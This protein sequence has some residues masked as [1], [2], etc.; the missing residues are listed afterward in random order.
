MARNNQSR[1]EA[2]VHMNILVVSQYFWPENFRINDLVQELKA[3]GHDLTVLTGLPNYPTG[4]WFSGYGLSAVGRNSWNKV[5]VVRVPV[6][7]RMSAKGWQL[8]LNYLS[9]AFSASL[10]GPMLCRGKFD[11]I[12][13][14]E[15]SP[16]TVGVPGMVMRKI[17]RAPM[18]F[19]VQDLWP[20]SL[21][22]T[23]AV[24]SQTILTIVGRMVRAIYRRCDQVL[25]QS[26]GFIEPAVKAGAR[27]ENIRYFPNWAEDF[28]H[29]FKLSPNAAQFSEVPEGFCIIFAGNLGTAQSLETIIG[30]AELLRNINGIQWVV[31][32]DGRRHDW[33]KSEIRRKGLDQ[34]VHFLGR[35]P[36]EEMPKYFALADVLLA[37]LRA[38]PVFSLTIPSKIQTY[39]ACGRPIVAALDGE[40]ARIINESGGGIAVNAGDAAGLARAVKQMYDMSPQERNLIA[41]K[42]RIYYEDHFDRKKLVQQLEH[43]MQES[44]RNTR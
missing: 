35:K 44:V 34:T 26:M 8:A 14:F 32:G 39:L 38:E 17:K 40:G 29:P 22:A 31:I 24:R 2:P 11:L 7:R 30:A 3:R 21:I 28:Y 13:V 25:V 37:T 36:P 18:L 43:W 6:M 4:Q 19:W 15:P 41:K 9:F 5:N 27:R 1:G 20:E 23:G 12:F 16:F 33:M 42:A 10:F